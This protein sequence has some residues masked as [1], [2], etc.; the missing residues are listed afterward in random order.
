MTKKSKAAWAGLATFVVT[1]LVT[2]F[3]EFEPG[4]ANMIW[5]SW[6]FFSWNY[7]AYAFD[8]GMLPRNLVELDGQGKGRPGHRTAFFW[9][10]LLVHLAFLA[11]MAFADK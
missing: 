7:F 9:G 4:Y 3:R 2:L 11:T 8:R 6:F 5:F 10:T 1:T